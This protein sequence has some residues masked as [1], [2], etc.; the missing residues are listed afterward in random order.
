MK[1]RK[2]GKHGGRESWREIEIERE[3][4]KNAGDRARKMAARTEKKEAA[5]A[6]KEKEPERQWE[7]EEE[8]TR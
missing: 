6:G 4:K 5:A 7:E 3:T 2:L 8:E 1:S